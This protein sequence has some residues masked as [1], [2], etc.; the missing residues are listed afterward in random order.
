[1]AAR[2]ADGTAHGHRLHDRIVCLRDNASR[3]PFESENRP[4]R[5]RIRP[6]LWQTLWTGAFG[7][8]DLNQRMHNKLIVV[9]AL[10]GIA[11]PLLDFAG[12]DPGAAV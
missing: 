6:S 4:A 7:F 2:R 8:H 5:S 1:M 3:S 11:F 9:D 10:V 12:F